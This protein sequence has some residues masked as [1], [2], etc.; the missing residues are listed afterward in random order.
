MFLFLSK[1]A[2]QKIEWRNHQI[3]KYYKKYPDSN[4]NSIDDYN[5]ISTAR[6]YASP[7]ESKHRIFLD[8]NLDFS[9]HKDIDKLKD[10]YHD[11]LKLFVTNVYRN[12]NHKSSVSKSP[13]SKSPVSKGPASK[14]RKLL[15]PLTHKKFDKNTEKKQLNTKLN[16][17]GGMNEDLSISP[18]PINIK[19]R[20]LLFNK[21]FSSNKKSNPESDFNH[22]DE[23]NSLS[24]S[25][26]LQNP[27]NNDNIVKLR[28]TLSVE[29]YQNRDHSLTLE[30]TIRTEEN[31]IINEATKITDSTEDLM[32]ITIDKE[33]FQVN[34]NEKLLH[35]LSVK[36]YKYSSL[37]IKSLKND[38][39]SNYFD[40]SK[41]S[42]IIASM[43]LSSAKTILHKES[44][45]SIN[46]VD[47]NS[48]KTVRNEYYTSNSSS[49]FYIDTQAK[50]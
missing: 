29:K 24:N 42:F 14:G 19:D 3:N 8:A 37:K 17:I 2:A 43:P 9:K 39:Y 38:V 47:Y 21:I 23:H 5:Y 16:T 40:N 30:Q 28:D 48:L 36:M 35:L 45:Q 11:P 20:K 1:L 41:N 46:K 26:D 15:A 22:N 33:S 6:K 10:P 4:D 13:V 12:H 34:S 7:L 31:F 18:L 50:T 49:P 25:P 27:L 44:D 32:P